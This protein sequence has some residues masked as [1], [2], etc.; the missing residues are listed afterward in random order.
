M[1]K[2]Y[3]RAVLLI[4]G[5]MG[6]IAYS[7]F[8]AQKE[9]ECLEKDSVNFYSYG[10]PT[11][12]AAFLEVEPFAF[13]CRLS[14][15]SGNCGVGLS[16]NEKGSDYKNWNLMDSLV[17]NLQSSEDFKEL[18]VQI[19]TYDADYTDPDNRN[20]MKPAL[21]ELHLSP[22]TKRYSIA[23]EHF[24]TPDYWFEQQKARNTHNAKRFSNVAGLEMFSGWKNQAGKPLELK[25]ESICA[26]GFSNTPFVVLVIYLSI[27][28]AVAISVRIKNNH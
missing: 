24:Y 14:N 4:S 27:L 28:I 11:V 26:E 9:M 20:T 25:A 19:L 21:K 17:L 1:R 15:E 16:F 8:P 3:L 2:R 7:L 6:V 18:I 23:M 12:G 22:G 5:I 10:N 13:K